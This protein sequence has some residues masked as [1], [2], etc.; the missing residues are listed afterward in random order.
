VTDPLLRGIAAAANAEGES[1]EGRAQHV[2]QIVRDRR[3]YRWVGIYDVAD[4]EATLLAASG[5][6]P[7]AVRLSIPILGA[8]SGIVIGTLDVVGSG[9]LTKDD[10]RFLDDCAAAAIG[11]FE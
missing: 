7:G 2:A 4:D 3:G 8:E 5:Q 1:R 10:E 11:I 6:G 9:D